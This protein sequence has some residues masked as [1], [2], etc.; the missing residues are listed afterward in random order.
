MSMKG[1]G[2]CTLIFEYAWRAISQDSIKEAFLLSRVRSLLT[3]LS[4]PD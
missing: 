1:E 3:V 2:V 4:N